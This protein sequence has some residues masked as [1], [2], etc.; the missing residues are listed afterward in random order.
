MS[1]DFS[2]ALSSLRREKGITQKNAAADL[3]ITQALL[4][5]YEKGIRE[6][7]LDFLKRAAGYYGVSA[8]YLLGISTNRHT[9]GSILSQ[10]ELPEDKQ[11]KI[12]TVLRA[13]LSLASEAEADGENSE[14]YFSDFFTLCI[15]EYISMGDKKN[16]NISSLCNLTKEE[17]FQTG[18]NV[19]FEDED[20]KPQ[21]LKTVEEHSLLLLKKYIE[22]AL[23]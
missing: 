9:S 8:D 13:F 5:H 23:K 22:N 4:S 20:F 10:T 21:C 11:L 2:N 15:K 6:C 3:G 19:P 7:N 14:L 12:N 18:R 17:L 1:T 16:G